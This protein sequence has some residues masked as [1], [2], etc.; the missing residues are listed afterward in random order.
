MTARVL[1]LNLASTAASSG[2][3]KSPVASAA[4]RA[5]GPMDSG[6]GSGLEGD[7]IANTGVHGGDDQAV[8]A[9]AREE[10]NYWEQRL[11]RPIDSGGFGENLTT[12]GLRVDD[13]LIG[14]QWAIGDEVVVQ[15]TGPRTPCGT[16]AAAMGVSGWVKTFTEHGNTGA[17][18]SIVR[19]G[20]VRTDD[21]ITVVRRGEH[22]ITVPMV[23]RAFMGDLDLASSVAEARVLTRRDQAQLEEMIRRRTS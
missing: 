13:A 8:Y 20:V 19:G 11:G 9:F 6:A 7:Y 14:D 12:T 1:S 5:P 16:F 23:F 21:P 3:H 4:L 17:Y 15:V 18:L 22:A 10:L 2:I